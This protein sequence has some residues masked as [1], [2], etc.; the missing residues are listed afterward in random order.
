MI[1]ATGQSGM[2]LKM[3]AE[4]DSCAHEKYRKPIPKHPFDVKTNNIQ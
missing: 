1:T 4:S 3:L 2:F